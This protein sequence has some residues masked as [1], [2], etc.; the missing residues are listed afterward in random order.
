MRITSLALGVLLTA[1]LALPV[2]AQKKEPE[3]G[4][5]IP[6]NIFF[7]GQQANQYLARER[8]LGAKVLDKN[9][10]A[11]GTIDD[12]ILNASNEV[13]GVVMGIGGILGVGQKQVG[14]RM[15]ALKVST[16][17]GKTTVTLPVATKEILAAVEAYQRPGPAN[18]K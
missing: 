7:K 12:L 11:I 17:D 6:S 14:V 8:L 2:L 18:K 1:I 3:K 10:Q 16:A 13:D 9:N 15:S 5:S 4:V